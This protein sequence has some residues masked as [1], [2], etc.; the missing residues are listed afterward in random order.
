MKG[1]HLLQHNALGVRCTGERLL[2]LVAQVRLLVVLVCPQLL[3]AVRA[4]LA[5]GSET[6]RL[7]A[8]QQMQSN[9]QLSAAHS[10]SVV[11]Q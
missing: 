10:C 7:T 3:T 11:R 5:S 4:K 9:A 2:P 1:L 6:A 8:A